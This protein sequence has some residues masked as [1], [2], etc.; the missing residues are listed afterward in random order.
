ML[1]FTF[2]F[3]MQFVPLKYPYCLRR[4]LGC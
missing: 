3:D 2:Y 4:R 1:L